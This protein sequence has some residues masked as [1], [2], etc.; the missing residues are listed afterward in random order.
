MGLLKKKLITIGKENPRLIG[1]IKLSKKD[2]VFSNKVIKNL[3]FMAM[4]G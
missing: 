4:A 1:L 2:L 3:I